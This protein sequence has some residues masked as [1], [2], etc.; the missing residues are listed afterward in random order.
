MTAQSGLQT[1]SPTRR[2]ALKWLLTFSIITTATGVVAPI[3][4]YLIPSSKKSDIYGGPISVG[5]VEDFPLGTGKVVSVNDKPVIVVNTKV[6]G[7]KVFSAVCT[8]LGCIVTW[9]QA[10]NVIHSPCH[11]G[12]FN[13]VTG[14]VV[15]GPPPRPLPLYE[16]AVKDGQVYIGKPLGKIYGT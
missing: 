14:N 6:G 2:E 12:L 11:D 7:I 1:I 16:L 9:N 3:L 15:A 5:K 4:A 13:P 10:K 8:H